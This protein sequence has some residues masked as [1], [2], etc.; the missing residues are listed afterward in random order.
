MLDKIDYTRPIGQR[1][2]FGDIRLEVKEGRNCRQ[3]LFYGR[4]G[5]DDMCR[6]FEYADNYDMAYYVGYCSPN[7]RKDATGVHFE[8]VTKPK[9]RSNRNHYGKFNKTGWGTIQV[10]TRVSRGQGST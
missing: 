5:R 6:L 2:Q 4:R 9:K 7:Y 3:C 8:E 10:P 1:F